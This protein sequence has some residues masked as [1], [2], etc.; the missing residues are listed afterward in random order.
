MSTLVH[1][2]PGTFRLDTPN[3]FDSSGTV[4]IPVRINT[5]GSDVNVAACRISYSEASLSFAGSSSFNQSMGI[6]SSFETFVAGAVDA[7]TVLFSGV[8]TTEG[9]T[10]RGSDLVV[11]ILNFSVID[12]AS[13]ASLFF[14]V[15]V[16]DCLVSL[17]NGNNISTGA[18]SSAYTINAQ[19]NGGQDPSDQEEQE[20]STGS[21]G[22]TAQSPDSN[23]TSSP[24]LP[25]QDQPQQSSN[26]SQAVQNTP[27]QNT[28]ASDAT[29]VTPNDNSLNEISETAMESGSELPVAG[30]GMIFVLFLGLVVFALLG[31]CIVFIMQR[32]AATKQTG[33]SGS[34]HTL[35]DDI[36][37]PRNV[38]E[39]V[40]SPHNK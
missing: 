11:G 18:T 14:D 32:Y 39:D 22:T 1:A 31:L 36:I 17:G 35:K 9:N 28:Q 8:N 13:P 12:A 5:N 40:I 34:S 4:S 23:S 20:V 30:F 19:G 10:S 29:I 2:D 25:T 6:F 16:E 33:I 3:T 7:N 37:A 21:S 24:D 38:S 27:S 26:S 15:N